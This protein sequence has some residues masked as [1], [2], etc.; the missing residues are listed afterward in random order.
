MPETGLQN[1]QLVY[2]RSYSTRRAAVAELLTVVREAECDWGQVRLATD[3]H[4]WD[5]DPE[6]RAG[7]PGAGEL[8]RVETY[9]LEP[10]RPG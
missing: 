7:R 9:R 1:G 4:D 3:L 5:E 10:V 8:I 6:S 2:V